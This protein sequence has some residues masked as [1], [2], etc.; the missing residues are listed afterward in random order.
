MPETT[1][2]LLKSMGGE[3]RGEQAN[4][5]SQQA[6]PQQNQ[7]N[8][9]PQFDIAAFNNF[10]KVLGR[11]FH[12][13]DEAKEFYSIPTKY[14][15]ETTA[16]TLTKK[17]KD[18][19]KKQFDDLDAKH[20][21]L[22][23][24]WNGRDKF[25]NPRDFFDSDESFRAN[26]LRKQFPDKDP[27]IMDA[28]SRMDEDK[29]DDINLLIYKAKLDHPKATKD[30]SVEDIKQWLSERVYKDV[31]F[32]DRENWDKSTKIDIAIKAEEIRSEFKKLKSSV[33]LPK[34]IDIEARNAEIIAQEN[35]K[36]ESNKAKLNVYAGQVIDE[37]L[38]LTFLDPDTKAELF[39][40]KPTITDELRAGM[41]EYVDELARKGEDVLSKENALKIAK[42]REEI[43]LYQYAPQLLKELKA[44]I[45]SEDAL[46]IHNFLHND[47][48]LSNKIAPLN[49]DN[50]GVDETIQR[51]VNH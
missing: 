13:L 36:Y 11:E 33:E 4:D 35:Q 27:N 48:L 46:A 50:K 44:R 23:T 10:S 12:T 25:I 30:M 17:E 37:N 18:D 21:E 24:K 41:A 7:N 14:T 32:S 42:R 39:K 49:G 26:Q 45:G 38:E 28:I 16:H 6:N 8:N 2:D 15:E 31:D 51:I 1:K 19:L 3:P 5:Q 9:E 40:F 47:T 43:L 22:E 29:E 20:K 34:A